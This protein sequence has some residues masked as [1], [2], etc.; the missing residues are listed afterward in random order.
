[1]ESDP[2][3]NWGWW[4]VSIELNCLQ[5]VSSGVRVTDLDCNSWFE[6]LLQGKGGRSALPLL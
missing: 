3:Q 2:R 1:M 5:F 6:K 4:Q